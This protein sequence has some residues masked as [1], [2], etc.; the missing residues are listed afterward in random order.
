MFRV[1][2]TAVAAIVLGASGAA[3]AAAPSSP[4]TAPPRPASTTTF[5]IDCR[6]GSAIRPDERAAVEGLSTTLF[7]RLTAGQMDSAFELLAPEIQA[8]VGREAFGKS[9]DFVRG[10]G[11]YGPPRVTR[12]YVLDLVGQPPEETTSCEGPDGLPEAYVA[13]DAFPR[14]AHV[15]IEAEVNGETWGFTSW[16]RLK[17]GRWAVYAIDV[18][19]IAVG[20]LGAA[21]VYAMARDQRGKN[22]PMSA[23]LLYRAARTLA[24]RGD[25]FALPL[26]SEIEDDIRGWDATLLEPGELPVF[27][28]SGRTTYGVQD[29]VMASLDGKAWIKLQ[30]WTSVWGGEREIKAENRRILAAFMKEHPDW[31]ESFVGVELTSFHPDGRQTVST[32][33]SQASGYHEVAKAAP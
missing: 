5:S 14:Q 7:E 4:A 26:R 28:T 1:L 24:G 19:D 3:V 13:I 10:V 30:R 18:R 17:D 6:T 32:L 23:W 12:T 20:R 11:A 8:S 27:W 22:H 2:F 33:Y 9:L 29:A 21:E 25:Y 31:A 15:A 16:L